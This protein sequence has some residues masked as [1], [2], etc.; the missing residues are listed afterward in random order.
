MP[1]YNI[2]NQNSTQY[3]TPIVSFD[4]NI[5]VNNKYSYN[6]NLALPTIDNFKIKSKYSPLHFSNDR[7]LNESK[8]LSSN[9]SRSSNDNNTLSEDKF[10]NLLVSQSNI[11]IANPWKQPNN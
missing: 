8:I 2:S 9:L 7:I 11:H 3:D 5:T 6:F 4:N 10:G 1:I